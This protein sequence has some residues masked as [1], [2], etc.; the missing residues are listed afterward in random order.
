MA[1]AK[2]IFFVLKQWSL[3]I[4]KI[5]ERFNAVP[6]IIKCTEQCKA[7]MQIAWLKLKFFDLAAVVATFML[8]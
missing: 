5:A 8:T 3:F 2:G 4:K 6:K 7:D 1:Y